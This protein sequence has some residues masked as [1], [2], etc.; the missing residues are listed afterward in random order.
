MPIVAELLDALPIDDALPTTVAHT[1]DGA[2]RQLT[3]SHTA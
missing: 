3:L 2:S 1:D